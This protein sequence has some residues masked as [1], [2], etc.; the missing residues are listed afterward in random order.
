MFVLL[1]III[2]IVS[3]VIA[4]IS[5][6]SEQKK[7]DEMQKAGPSN[8]DEPFTEKGPKVTEPDQSPHIE[9]DIPETKQEDAKKRLEEM[10]TQEEVIAKGGGLDSVDDRAK[11]NEIFGVEPEVK[12]NEPQAFNVGDETA[13]LKIEENVPINSFDD[14]TASSLAD[15]Q[16]LSGIIDIRKM[17]KAKKSEKT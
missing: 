17:A 6:V 15:S 4:L 5:L 14:S 7:I 11:L 12:T 3:F 9:S 2:L 13:D 1:G 10:V 8:L 16:T